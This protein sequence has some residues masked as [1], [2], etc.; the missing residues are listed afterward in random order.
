MPYI[1]LSIRLRC[2]DKSAIDYR[3]C[4]SG[5]PSVGGLFDGDGILCITESF[6]QEIEQNDPVPEGV[7]TATYWLEDD[8][9]LF[10]LLY[11]TRTIGFNGFKVVGTDHEVSRADPQTLAEWHSDAARAAAPQP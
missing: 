2:K 3:N 4:E 11:R 8:D 9:Q 1:D 5:L 6:E 10:L 7:K